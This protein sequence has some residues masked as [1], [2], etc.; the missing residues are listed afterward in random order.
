[1]ALLNSQSL[2]PGNNIEMQVYCVI[3]VISVR[4]F[5]AEILFPLPLRISLS[6]H[7]EMPES[8]LYAGSIDSLLRAAR[9]P[10]HL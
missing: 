7:S 6:C 1:M 4:I 5:T 3:S 8:N 10:R 9:N 2:K